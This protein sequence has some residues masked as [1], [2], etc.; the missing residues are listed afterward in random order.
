[1]NIRVK[2]TADDIENGRRH[3]CYQCPVAL[4]IN[5]AFKGKIKARV[6]VGMIGLYNM[7]S[8]STAPLH[9]ATI[10]APVEVND[11]VLAF[12][13]KVAGAYPFEFDLPVPDEVAE[14]IK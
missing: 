5:R 4:A 11:F 6:D 2:V 9:A 7:I 1:M 13:H 3:A 10:V 14:L 12:D 8:K